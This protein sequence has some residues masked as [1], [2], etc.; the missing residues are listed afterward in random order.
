M[1]SFL[2]IASQGLED[3]DAACRSYR[4]V[5]QLD[6]KNKPAQEMVKNSAVKL[7]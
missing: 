2:G 6:P 3:K 1:H 4:K 7:S 5:I